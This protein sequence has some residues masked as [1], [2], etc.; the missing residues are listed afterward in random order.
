MRLKQFSVKGYKNFRQEI[1]LEDMGTIC[2]IHGENNVGKS[3]LLEAM[4]LFFQ[5][6]G[7]LLTT[8]PGVAIRLSA[9]ELAPLGFKTSEIFT[10]GLKNPIAMK[11]ILMSKQ[12]EFAQR[13]IQQ[14]K[15]SEI[16]ISIELKT[17]QNDNLECE[18]TT[19]KSSDGTDFIDA[20]IN[21]GLLERV[22]TSYK[23]NPFALVGVDR[24]ISENEIETVRNIVPQTLLLK[25]YDMR[26][27]LD[28][29]VYKSELFVRTLQRFNDVL[30]EGEFVAIF[31]R[32]TNRANLAFQ[33]KKSKFG[34]MP[35]E[36]LG[37]GIQQ[38]VALVARL[39]VSDATFVAIE[40]PEL[41]LRYTLQLRLREI[42]KEIAEDPFGPQ[43]IFISSHSPAFEFGEHF[44][45]MRFSS[46]GPTVEHRPIQEASIFTQHYADAPSTLESAPMGYVSSDGLVK[47]PE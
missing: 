3:N 36:I 37:S 21:S 42:F 28:D 8:A 22:F 17:V 20:H 29:S 38:I 27:S 10:L 7:K 4:Q 30:G 12:E 34:R 25:L 16:H 35:I 43:Q 41:N 39:L 47:L 1:V 19:L 23:E 45:A 24:R 14:L 5:L 31:N 11:A 40:E 44:Y 33:P 46:E 6:C 13:A 18:L 26:D 15:T 9:K 2:A 32:H